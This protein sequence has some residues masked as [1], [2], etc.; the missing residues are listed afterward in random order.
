MTET[1]APDSQQLRLLLSKLLARK[2]E[3]NSGSI[4]VVGVDE[5]RRTSGERWPALADK[6]AKHMRQMIRRKV[7]TLLRRWLFLQVTRVPFAC[8]SVPRRAT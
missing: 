2:G 1:D 6:V 4:H 5:L 7:P 3:L 8:L